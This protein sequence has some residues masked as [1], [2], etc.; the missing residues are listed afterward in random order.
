MST[1]ENIFIGVSD[2]TID[3]I[4]V[5]YK[6]HQNEHGSVSAAISNIKIDFIDVREQKK[7]IYIEAYDGGE[8]ILNS[9]ELMAKIRDKKRVTSVKPIRLPF[10]VE[11]FDEDAILAINMNFKQI[12]YHL[13]MLQAYMNSKGYTSLSI[14]ASSTENIVLYG[15]DHTK[16]QNMIARDKRYFYWATDTRRLYALF[17]V[18]RPPSPRVS[19]SIAALSAILTK[20]F[21]SKTKVSENISVSLGVSISFTHI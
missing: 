13:S 19:A 1:Y 14:P 11:A 6:N 16:P 3:Y 20:V 10:T 17:P 12:E 8:Y 15:L 5:Y 4:K 21:Y 9:S 18:R 7:K 2:L